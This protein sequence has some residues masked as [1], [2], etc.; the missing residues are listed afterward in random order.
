MRRCDV[1][2]DPAVTSVVEWGARS[3]Q[4]KESALCYVHGAETGDIDAPLTDLRRLS[5][6]TGYPENGLCFILEALIRNSDAKTS[7]EICGAVIASAKERFGR[8][9]GEALAG[10]QI[11]DR[12]DLGTA[13]GALVK[14][15]LLP[16]HGVDRRLFDQLF[17]LR[18]VLDLV[19]RL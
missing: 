12:S 19:G 15:E 4:S 11:R 16:D 18:H 9:C 8:E 7:E 5:A 6:E 3:G 2:Q 1:C 17:E 13:Y 10:W 14:A